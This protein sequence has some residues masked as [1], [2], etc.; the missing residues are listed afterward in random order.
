[1]FGQVDHL[2]DKGNDPYSDQDTPSSFNLDKA[3]KLK[4]NA[5][6]QMNTLWRLE[7]P[8]LTNNMGKDSSVS[9]S[10]E[11]AFN[12]TTSF[13][14]DMEDIN[15]RVVT[16]SAPMIEYDTEFNAYFHRNMLGQYGNLTFDI[17]EYEDGKTREFLNIW[18]GLIGPAAHRH[19]PPYFYKRNL[20]L[21]RMST[22][23]IDLN[24]D[25]F[26]GV[27]L[28]SIGDISHNYDSPEIMKYNVTLTVDDV[29][30]IKLSNEE[31]INKATRQLQSKDLSYDLE[32]GFP[33]DDVS[34]KNI[35]SQL[36]TSAIL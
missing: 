21:F 24:V 23:K 5:A 9:G 16:V 18:D 3:V 19:N 25:I 11:Q 14:G 10:V 27:V 12:N 2:K 28:N 33:P 17:E 7:L 15:S 22:T 20:T 8:D 29:E 30:H 35:F 13:D 36:A 31:L 34:Q 32:L 6:P 4:E 1:M 26:K